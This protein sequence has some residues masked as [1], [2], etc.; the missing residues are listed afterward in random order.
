MTAIHDIGFVLDDGDG[1][2]V[3]I[4]PAVASGVYTQREVATLA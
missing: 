2:Q 3:T 1:T 4:N